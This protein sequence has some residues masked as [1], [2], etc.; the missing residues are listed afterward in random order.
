ML[1]DA[2]PNLS[3]TLD[4]LAQPTNPITI[5]LPHNHTAHENLNW[6]DPVK[7]D[8][9]LPCRL[10]QP[11]L[12]S[13]LVLGHGIRVVDFVAENEEGGLAEVF[14]GEEGVELGF[15]LGE[16][17]G[18]FGVDEEDDAADFGEVVFPEATSLLV[19]AEVEGGEADAADGEFFAS[20]MQG[21]LEDGYA[22]VLEHMEELGWDV[23]R[24][25]VV[26]RKEGYGAY[27]GLSGIVETEEEEF[28]V[29]VGQAQVGQQV[30]DWKW[31][32]QLHDYP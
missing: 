20:W 13:Q 26:R 18:V 8:L 32:R 23:S 31:F 21:W 12:M 7:R 29:L 27:S 17:F 3:R 19:A 1:I 11:Q 28:G 6:S 14:H 22:V 24:R 15:R 30:P 25:G 9:A 16:A 5:T 10:I 2:P 4:I